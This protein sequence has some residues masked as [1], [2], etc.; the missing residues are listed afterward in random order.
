MLLRRYSKGIAIIMLM[1]FG[2]ELI[3]PSALWAL[4]GG[5]SQPEVNS[6]E[7]VGTN[8]MV[9]LSTGDFNY[10]IPLMVVPGPNGGYPINLAYHAGIGMEQEASWVGLGWNIN[11]G[12][13]TRNLRGVP[14]DF[15]GDTIVQKMNLK[16]NVTSGLTFDFGQLKGD[17]KE[18]F[19]LELDAYKPKW[20]LDTYFN[21][22]RGI[23]FGVTPTPIRLLGNSV[24]KD[25]ERSFIVGLQFSFDSQTG[26][27]ADLK[28]DFGINSIAS[29]HFSERT[30]GSFGA[31]IG[32][33]SQQGLRSLRFNRQHNAELNFASSS[34]FPGHN[35]DMSGFNTTAGYTLTHKDSL[36]E[37]DKALK[38]EK[39][40][41]VNGLKE[42]EKSM[43]AYGTLYSQG[44]E[45]DENSD[46][47]ANYL[48]D[49]NVYNDVPI[50]K[51]SK[52][53]GI[54][55]GTNDIYTI[56]GQGIGG[57]F[58]AHRNDIGRFH[59]SKSVTRN[60]SIPVSVEVGVGQDA[61][62]PT[63]TD[64]HIGA[65]I[66]TFLNGAWSYSG[67]LKKGNEEISNLDFEDKSS[68]KP[69]YEPVYFK[70][71]GEM[72][73]V[74][75]NQWDYMNDLDTTALEMGLKWFE[76]GIAPT[77]SF[78]NRVVG[79]TGSSPHLS[80]NGWEKD[81][82][83]K[84]QNVQFK[85]KADLMESELYWNR[86]KHIF[87]EGEMPV[88]GGG[89]GSTVY[90]DEAGGLEPEKGL[91]HI[92]QY[93]IL[94]AD[95]S[96][97]Y[98]GLPAYNIKQN[99]HVFANTSP[100]DIPPE[101]NDA[102]L[103]SYNTLDASLGNDEGLDN[104]YSSN[105]LP[106]YVHAH[107]LTQI[108]SAD[109][110]DVTG[111]GASEDDL[112]YYTKF[113]Y[114]HPI[115]Y[116][117]REPFYDADY[118][119]GYYSNEADDKASFTFGEKEMYYVHSIETKTHIA[120]FELGDRADGAGVSE[121]HQTPES[122]FGAKQK[123]LKT[124]KL[125]SKA[126]I[127]EAGGVSFTEPLQIVYLKYNYELCQGVL[128]NDPTEFLDS[129]HFV[130]PNNPTNTEGKLTLKEVSISYNGNGKGR[131]SPYT[132]DY[133]SNQNYSRLNIDRWGNYQESEDVNEHEVNPYT[134]QD[135]TEEERIA[136]ASAWCLSDINLPSG[137]SVN[138]RYE[139]DDYGY[140][141]NERAA[142][143]VKIIGFT[144]VS[145][146][147]VP[148]ST[149]KFK[150]K[151][152][153]L[154]LWFEA[155][156][157]EGKIGEQ[158][159]LVIADY[160]KGLDQIYFKIFNE[161]KRPED[162]GT[163][164]AKDYVVGYAHVDPDGEFGADL[165]LNYGY[166]DLLKE[167]YKSAGLE[168]FKTHP[169]RKAGWQYLRYSRTDLFNNLS[170]LAAADD[171]ELSWGSFDLLF[172]S[173]EEAVAMLALGQYN[174]YAIWNYCKKF[175]DE[176]DSFIRLN[177]PNKLKYGG[178]HRVQGIYLSDN[179]SDEDGGRTF[180]TTYTY[181]NEDGSTSGV[182]DYEPIIGGEENALKSPKEYNPNDQLLNFQHQDLYLETPLMEAL[183]PS[184]RIVYGRIE[185]KRTGH[186]PEDVFVGFSTE[187]SEVG[188][189]V[190]EH[191]TA[192]DFPVFESHTG[193]NHKGYNV[194]LYVPFVGAMSYNN[195]GF[196]QGYKLELNDM[197]G[198]VKSTAIYPH[199][200]DFDLDEPIA[201][202][203]YK[204]KSVEAS[205]N[206]EMRLVNE[207][208]VLDAHG[209]IREA[210]VGVQM[211][212]TVYE[213]ENSSYAES[214]MS[215]SNLDILS[216]PSKAIFIPVP[217]FWP[218]INHSQFVYR[219][220]STSKVIYRTGILEEV[221]VTADGSAV[222][223]RNE[224]YDAETG[225]ALLTSVNNEWDK[226]VYNYQYAAHW[227]YDQ[228]GGAYE[229][230]GA[231]IYMEGTSD[232]LEL[233][234]NNG[235]AVIPY[236]TI[237]EL[238]D[239]ITV[240]EGGDLLTYYV[241]EFIS[242]DYFQ[243]ED[244]DGTSIGFG[245]EG[246]L[247][248]ITRSGN[249][250]LQ[251]VK[252]GSIVAL[253]DNFL[254]ADGG[255]PSYFKAWNDQV[256]GA[257]PQYGDLIENRFYL[258]KNTAV[259]EPWPPGDFIWNYGEN[260]F[261]PN[262]YDCSKAEFYNLDIQASSTEFYADEI[263]FAKNSQCQG[264]LVFDDTE[265]TPRDLGY[266]FE[267]DLGGGN[268]SY[269]E[270][271]TD[272]KITSVEKDFDGV[273]TDVTLL[274]IPHDKEFHAAWVTVGFDCF[275][276]C[277]VA[278][279][280][281]SDAIEFSDSWLM[282]YAD[283]GDPIV[284][285][286]IHISDPSINTYRYGKKGIWRAKHT[287]LYQI[288]RQQ[289]GP[290]TAT[291]NNIDGEY[292]PW[293]PYSWLEGS[294]NPKWD[295]VSE[296][297]RYSPYGFGLEEKSRLSYTEDEGSPG[298]YNESAIYSS[299][300][301]GYHNSVVIATSALANYYEV[302]F[303]SFEQ[304]YDG[305]TINSGHIDL[306]AAVGDISNLKSHTG[307]QS[308]LLSDGEGMNFTSEFF[309][310]DGEGNLIE[311]DAA[312][313]QGIVGKEYVVSLW[314]NVEDEGSFG[315]LNIDGVSL[316]T[317]ESREIIDGW[318]K[319]EMRFTMPSADLVINYVSTGET[320]LDDIRVGP[321]E[322]GMVTY[323]YDR[324]NLWLVAELDGL[325]YATFYNYDSEGNLV[326]VKKETEEGIITVSTARSNT[327]QLP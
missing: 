315:E 159:D 111:N 105:E 19:G 292:E 291:R 156:A 14:D 78:K 204:Y 43:L 192:K 240:E 184:P 245:P 150:L 285:G 218:K 295:W 106:A 114:H 260:I 15:S 241:S 110:V 299:Q 201:K 210:L 131:L 115:E 149:D 262:V 167:D 187:N 46:L 166:V 270:Q 261:V 125:Y 153:H 309:A 211:D 143:M 42:R 173:V 93:E 140:V 88:I 246:K 203:E 311:D 25:K 47:D 58:S 317:V 183:Y 112:G 1:T 199:S 146:T 235:G 301:Y 266:I 267:V 263:F 52:N 89:T 320:Y 35:F 3:L 77:P 223:T 275:D 86:G 207:V 280:L 189:T 38:I 16:E 98:Y 220:L 296:I 148:T 27:G 197:S 289:S 198:K 155:D 80:N 55:V 45:V 69:R 284:D 269:T 293:E 229:N 151:K 327:L 287:H 222:S 36:G 90:Y 170:D 9:D 123:Y 258:N 171:D 307:N 130:A 302:G 59:P 191:Y 321:Y 11:P 158:R 286:V 67:K 255:L 31:G 251:A 163:D 107:L 124:I 53:M 185:E 120:V 160:L 126:D 190:T 61:L 157:L 314:V 224:L 298:D 225:Q 13:I 243:L 194:P 154:R 230:Y 180:G 193:L 208:D 217:T 257:D 213:E 304:E 122:D 249:R 231:K 324:S 7:P 118:I 238:G 138:V 91:S 200:A 92:H 137:G 63:A 306:D 50:T 24:K 271:F 44:S 282:P 216:D 54:P 214:I 145:T 265:P 278:D 179:W 239:E 32:W 82:I 21:N 127:V 169:M 71:G 276:P 221:I 75:A 104:Y 250:N 128:N 290:I 39:R 272:F 252:S 48:Q 294:L 134:R 264:K 132:F 141:Q 242:T 273:I 20:Q 33:N 202:T 34:Y 268:M 316:S 79:A 81:R 113:N 244:R 94:K 65:D 195:N 99:S 2:Q 5:P 186:F 326:Q 277:F 228:M 97:Y 49:I 161:L 279:I 109:Y 119:K 178:G 177:S 248:V 188:I 22:Y 129:E 8:Q 18:T 181:T 142:Q 313:L 319:L 318:K 133:T 236:Q 322:G 164:K 247:G 144:D 174:R 312:G 41:I 305:A 73:A 17:R 6:F 28:A 300:L 256:T 108:T 253:S 121:E 57:S 196:S 209:E 23:G 254:Y 95:G 101:Y 103:I 176:K 168:I 62:N 227:N 303:N 26:M 308:L 233:K 152:N 205:R 60:L 70:M 165:S 139:A 226:P 259:I 325:N 297:T 310:V 56:A 136:N 182:A 74:P 76:G 40:N 281:H 64:F 215:E 68:E 274:N 84:T 237:L 206:G 30:Y 172:D 85:T 83:K 175:S 147:V 37:L 87:N 234:T 116:K 219:G 100:V 212:F 288:D 51:R 117:W 4:T 102:D 96:K 162:G 10:N 66:A 72:T 323:V 29:E 232:A 12:A 283:V 135:L